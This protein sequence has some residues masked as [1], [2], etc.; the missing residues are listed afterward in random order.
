MATAKARVVSRRPV[1]AGHPDHQDLDIYWSEEMAA[2]LETWGEGN[3]WNE[4]QFLLCDRRGKALD[5]ACGTG[6]AM[7]VLSRF[8]RLEIT[9]VDISDLLIGKA[10]ERGI[11][12]E[13]LFVADATRLAFPD[14]SFD[15]AYSIGSFEH[16]TEEGLHQAIAECYRVVTRVAFHMVPVSRSGKD[17]GWMKTQ[18]SFFNNSVEWWLDK[19]RARF[20]EVLVLDSTWD[21]TFSVGK[22]FV[23]LKGGAR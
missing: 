13:R 10:R 12:L 16:F 18:Q 19:Y 22:W 6:K 9:G 11:A 5:I 23:C 15:Y 7:Q 20:P 2:L 17:E 4:I 3:V 14:G 21:D 8:H 1:V